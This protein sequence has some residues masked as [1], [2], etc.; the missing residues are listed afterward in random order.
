MKI[1]VLQIV[2]GCFFSDPKGRI[3][4]EEEEGLGIVLSPQR[5]SF[6]TG[7]HVTKQAQRRPGSPAEVDREG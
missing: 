2:Y 1:H 6:G 7:C 5:R 4:E 3:K